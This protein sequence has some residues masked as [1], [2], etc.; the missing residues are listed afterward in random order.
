MHELASFDAITQGEMQNLRSELDSNQTSL[1]AFNANIKARL[2]G[3]A[4]DSISG[5]ISGREELELN[6]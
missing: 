6:V 4:L 1:A 3:F 2:D 5:L